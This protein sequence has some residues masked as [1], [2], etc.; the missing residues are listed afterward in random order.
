MAPGDFVQKALR[1]RKSDIL[2]QTRINGRKG[3]FYLHFEHQR[4]VDQEMAFRIIIYMANIWEQH[5]KQYP[6]EKQIPLVVPVVLYQGEQRWT[7]PTDLHE[8]LQVPVYLKPYIPQFSY[9]LKDLSSFSDEQIQGEIFVQLSLLVMK[10]IDSPNMRQLFKYKLMPLIVKL[11][12]KQ[13]GLEYIETM[14]YYLSNTS[15]YLDQEEVLR[16]FDESPLDKPEKEIIMTLAEQWKQEGK[17]IGIEQ[18]EKSG[19]LKLVK[20]LLNLKFGD[21]ALEYYRLLETSSVDLLEKTSK[22]LLKYDTLE[23]VLKDVTR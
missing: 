21:K 22:N 14:L 10:H 2:Y 13:T 18:G 5:Q 15:E 6:A 8:M 11:F 17:L 1:N 19:K 16:L 3:Y 23:E 20:Q 4:K 12:Q 9:L 7:A